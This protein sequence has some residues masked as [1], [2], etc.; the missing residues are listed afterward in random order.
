MK[1]LQDLKLRKKTEKKIL[2]WLGEWLQL[3]KD[4]ASGEE[5]TVIRANFV[6]DDFFFFTNCKDLMEENPESLSVEND[7]KIRKRKSKVMLQLLLKTLM[8]EKLG[9]KSPCTHCGY[10]D[11]IVKAMHNGHYV[12]CPKC[13]YLVV[14]GYLDTMEKSMKKLLKEL[15]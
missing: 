13:K 6:D 14:N 2:R 5:G 8:G 1:T 11:R 15:E 10:E 9:R 3:M 12:Y 7:V 4:Q